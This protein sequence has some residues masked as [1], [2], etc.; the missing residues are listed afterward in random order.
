MATLYL[1]NLMSVFDWNYKEQAYSS[2]K[3]KFGECN[4]YVRYTNN[5]LNLLNFTNRYLTVYENIF[6]PVY[7]NVDTYVRL[8]PKRVYD[9]LVE[10]D[11]KEL[12]KLNLVSMQELEQIYLR[13]YSTDMV[14]YCGLLPNRLQTDSEEKLPLS[15]PYSEKWKRVYKAYH[16]YWDLPSLKD[17]TLSDFNGDEIVGRLSWPMIVMLAQNGSYSKSDLEWVCNYSLSTSQILTELKNRGLPTYD[18]T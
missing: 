14:L 3:K 17:K 16:T 2:H 15:L 7:Q 6:V 18:L 10:E 13:Y 11:A 8:T 12:L 9:F 4:F 5:K 1:Q